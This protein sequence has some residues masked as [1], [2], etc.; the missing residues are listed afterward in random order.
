MEQDQTE[1]IPVEL[2][3]LLFEQE[4]LF[5]MMTSVID[6]Q[7]IEIDHLMT[8][9]ACNHEYID[10]LKETIANLEEELAMAKAEKEEW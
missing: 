4:K 1:N 10:A 9:I 6:N 7:K 5:S 2:S 3:L 8:C